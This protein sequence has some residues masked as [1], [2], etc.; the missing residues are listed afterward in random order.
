LPGVLASLAAQTY[1]NFEVL[2]SDDASTDRTV[3]ICEAHANAD[4]RFRVLRQTARLGWV[5]NANR[6]LDVAR[7]KY[8]FFAAHDDPVEPDCVATLVDALEASPDA[9]LAYADVD[10]GGR[11]HEYREVEGIGSRA[12][13]ARRI[14]LRRGE[15]WIP[16]RGLFRLEVA[17]AIGG[18]RR[19]LAGEYK[20]DHLWL[21]RLALA[22]SFVRV[23]R[24]LVHKQVRPDTLSA[25]WGREQTPWH[26]AALL[27]AGVQEVWRASPPPGEQLQLYLASCRFAL[28]AL[29]NR[30]VF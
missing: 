17:H 20:A 7:G 3:E 26:S 5:G 22:G 6:L 30:H 27:L 9:V 23:P 15:W 10:I 8:A 18:L 14:I 11:L 25:A 13:R 1:S 19:H 16:F 2:I 29:W 4:P 12:E 24:V 21:L 28:W